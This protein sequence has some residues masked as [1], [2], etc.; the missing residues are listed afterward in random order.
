M[1]RWCERQQ[2]S[3]TLDP[4][5]LGL[6]CGLR[7]DAGVQPG[8]LGEAHQGVGATPVWALR[9]GPGRLREHCSRVAGGLGLG[10]SCC[11]AGFLEQNMEV[12]CRP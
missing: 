3:P 6:H 8:P 1:Q 11:A 7:Y 9:C 2:D 5:S 4:E 12:Y 10:F